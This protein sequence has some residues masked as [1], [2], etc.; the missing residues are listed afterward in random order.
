[1]PMTLEQFIRYIDL[2]EKFHGELWK[3]ARSPMLLQAIE[4]H[5]ALPFAAPGALVFTDDPAASEA[6][7]VIALEH[8]RAIVEAIAHGEGARAEAL[9]REHAHVARRALERALRSSELFRRMPGATLIKTAER[10]GAEG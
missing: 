6:A 4:R 1:M 10:P 9:A 7:A 2:N 5:V 8:H 3:L